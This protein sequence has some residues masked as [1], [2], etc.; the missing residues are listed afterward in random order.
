MFILH[1]WDGDDFV[2]VTESAATSEILISAPWPGLQSAS[3]RMVGMWDRRFIQAQELLKSYDRGECSKQTIEE[4]FQHQLR[5]LICLEMSEF[6]V[7]RKSTFLWQMS[8]IFGNV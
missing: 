7:W 6:L 4:V 3:Y 1:K 5:Q 8:F 2:S